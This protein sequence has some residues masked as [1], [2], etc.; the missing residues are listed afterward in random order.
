MKYTRLPAAAG[1]AA[2]QAARLHVGRLGTAVRN[3]VQL[4]SL[5]YQRR[6]PGDTPK[7]ATYGYAVRP[8][9][10]YEVHKLPPWLLLLL[11]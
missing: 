6:S 9:V 5:R 4:S 8:Q 2:P 11:S 7:I 3:A 1:V 10:Y